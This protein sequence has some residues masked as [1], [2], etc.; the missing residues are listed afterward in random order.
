M[1]GRLFEILPK[2]LDRLAN[3]CANIKDNR[4]AGIHKM[5]HVFE[6]IPTEFRKGPEFVPEGILSGPKFVSETGKRSSYD[7]FVKL[8]VSTSSPLNSM[9]L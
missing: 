5:G 3:V 8:H 6:R 7:F 2:V 9:K 1:D 4:S